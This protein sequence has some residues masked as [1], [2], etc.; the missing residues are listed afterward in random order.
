[1]EG[2]IG[3]QGKDRVALFRWDLTSIPAG[4]LVREASVT[5]TVVGS[6]SSATFPIVELK[7]D[8]AER[9]SSW[10][11]SAPGK[12][13]ET[14]GALGAQD[15]G[16]ALGSLLAKKLGIVTVPLDAA[17]VQGWIDRPASNFGFIISNSETHDALQVNSRECLSPADRPKLTIHFHPAGTRKVLFS[18]N[19]NGGRGKFPGGDPIDGALSIG[20]SGVQLDRLL[21]SPISSTLTVRFRIKPL[22]GIGNFEVLANSVKA[23]ANAWYRVRGLKAN[24]WN[25]VEVRVAE[26]KVGYLMKGPSLEGD[27]T[28]FLKLYF[29]DGAPEARVLIDDF[30][31]LE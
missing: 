11:L 2:D 28:H 4:R 8:W 23:E 6:G 13:W 30:E 27:S 14:P 12:P 9:G 17:V 31:L 19:F 24:E 21:P 3:G 16:A 5:F 29:D 20:K 18:E 10:N 1:M 7:R 26:M 22:F 25:T 15:R